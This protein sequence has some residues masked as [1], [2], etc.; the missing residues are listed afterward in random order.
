MSAMSSS[1]TSSFRMRLPFS[2]PASAFSASAICFS[3]PGMMLNR[4][5]PARWRAL[6]RSAFSS[7]L[8]AVSRLSRSVWS[9]PIASFS[10]FQ[11]ARMAFAFS[12]MSASS[13]S[14][15]AR[16]AALASS[17]SL[18]SAD[19]SISMRMDLRSASSISCGQE[20]ISVRSLAAASSIR[21]MA[22]SGRNRSAMYWSESTAAATRAPSRIFTPW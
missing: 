10:A 22:L 8:F 18:R 14:S 19:S 16:R 6:S 15:S 13:F 7:S 9:F 2:S 3:M 4:S 1:V 21:S 17:F 11:E 12:F 20:S 5:S